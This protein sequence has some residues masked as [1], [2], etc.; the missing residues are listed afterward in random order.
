MKDYLEKL[1]VV[2]SDDDLNKV[3]AIPFKASKLKVFLKYL[4]Q[5]CSGTIMEKEALKKY[6]RVDD[7]MYR[8]MKSV[9][10]RKCYDVICPE[11]SFKLLDLLSRYRLVENFKRELLFQEKKNLLLKDRRE[12]NIFYE[13][14]LTFFL[15]LPFTAQDFKE[16]T[17]YSDLSLKYSKGN[18]NELQSINNRSKIMVVRMIHDYFQN[19]LKNANQ[20]YYEKTF[21]IINDGIK[22]FDDERLKIIALYCNALYAFCIENDFLKSKKIFLTLKSIPEAAKLLPSDFFYSIDGFF[23][24]CLYYLNEFDDCMEMFARSM[25]YNNLFFFNQPHL[26]CRLCELYMIKG[27][28]IEAK[29]ILDNHL[30]R[31]LKSGE[32][33]AIGLIAII[34]SKYYM[35]RS[36]LINAFEFFKMARKHLNNK[37]YIIHDIDVRTLEVI[38]FLLVGEMKFAKTIHSRTLKFIREK[39]KTKKLKGE[40]KTQEVIKRLIGFKLRSKSIF[41]FDLQI[42]EVFT[43]H[44]KIQGILLNRIFILNKTNLNF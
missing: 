27:K 31:F 6:L 23:G 43:G 5:I 3:K 19:D 30:N 42:E 11:G 35:L 14:V 16:L 37:Y 4:I 26:L 12:K 34:F 20:K 18:D 21:Q 38:Y 10:L 44:Y 25:K 17:Y 28:M 29:E 40:M 2:L 7:K 41:N 9:L 39:A 33:D 24:T 8:K 1:I 22:K 36:D 15:R 13:A 32:P